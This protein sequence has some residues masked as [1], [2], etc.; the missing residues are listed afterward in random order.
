NL[1]GLHKS[2]FLL[3]D[4]VEYLKQ[5][6]SRYDFIFCCGVL[7]HMQD[8]L[9][10]IELMAS[11]TDRIFVWT[12]Y[13]TKASYPDLVPTAVMRGDETYTYHRL[14]YGGRELGKFWGGNKPSASWLSREDIL[15]AFKQQGLVN[16]EL[17]GE[18]LQ[19]P[20]GPCFSMSF[21]RL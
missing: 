1:M 8:P 9:R 12:H 5:D 19:H 18:D 15:R 7:Y 20:A 14:P 17:H 11:H 2:R 10:L 6:Q 3:G 16:S 21:W 4:F 13:H